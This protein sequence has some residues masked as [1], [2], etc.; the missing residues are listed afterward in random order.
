MRHENG[1]VGAPV[2]RAKGNNGDNQQV[3]WQ[4][5]NPLLTAMRQR[6]KGMPPGSGNWR[7]QTSLLHLRA[8]GREIRKTARAARFYLPTAVGSGPATFFSLPSFGLLWRKTE[9]CNKTSAWGSDW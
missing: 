6:C 1:R 3:L 2:R 7:Q 4:R 8:Q 5:A 9:V